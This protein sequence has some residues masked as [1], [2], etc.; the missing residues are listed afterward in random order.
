MV[1]T[2][3]IAAIGTLVGDPARAAILTTLMDGRALTASELARVAGVTP[4]TASSH[5]SLLV[6][7]DLIEVRKQGRHRYHRLARPEVARMLEGIMQIASK[8]AATL[9]RKVVTGPRDAAMLKARTCYDHFAGKLSIVLT[10]RLIEVGAIELDN[11]AGL[12][13]PKGNAYL[14]ERGIVIDDPGG[15]G[16]KTSR[17]L[18]RPCLDW[19][20]RRF[21][22]AGK[23]GAAICTHFFEQGYVRRVN[24]SRAVTIT[25]KGQKALKEKFGISKIA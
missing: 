4:Q 8:D 5:L 16:R 22:I 11:E 17:P 24:D 3:Q 7:A 19:S 12:V 20:E 21:H 18:C 10:D 2:N 23:L 1:S 15:L 14:R 9:Q 6:G 25:P 13:T